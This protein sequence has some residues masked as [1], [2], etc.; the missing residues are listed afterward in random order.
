L[1]SKL[2][3]GAFVQKKIKNVL[4]GTSVLGLLVTTTVV[5]ANSTNNTNEVNEYSK[6][7]QEGV[8]N[9]VVVTTAETILTKEVATT[10][11]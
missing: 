6:E 3:K 1:N 5:A 9:K 7:I 11:G 4:I 8:N 2:F 10:L